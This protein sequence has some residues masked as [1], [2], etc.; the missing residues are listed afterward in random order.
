MARLGVELGS[1]LGL[2]TAMAIRQGHTL[3]VRYVM[4]FADADDAAWLARL[5]EFPGPRNQQD[6]RPDSELVVLDLREKEFSIV[7]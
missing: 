4:N 2:I 7:E 6:L 5:K 1:D 3:A